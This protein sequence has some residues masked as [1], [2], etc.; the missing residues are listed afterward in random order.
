MPF[1]PQKIAERGQKSNG[2]NMI[3]L[4]RSKH[5]NSAKIS[6]LVK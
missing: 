1:S 2:C 4:E 5:T 3:T 6:F